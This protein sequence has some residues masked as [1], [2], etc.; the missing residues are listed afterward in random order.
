MRTFRLESTQRFPYPRRDIFDFFSRAENLERITPP[1]LRFAV[2]TP[3]PIRMREGTC[4]DYRLRL[5]GIPL[6]WRS[7]ITLWDPPNAFIDIQL[8]GP[9]R[10]WAHTHTFRDTAHGTLV[11]DRVEYAVP[12]GELVNR[13]IVRPDLDRVFEYRRRALRVLFPEPARD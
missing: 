8:C 9:Y 4:I 10:H 6:A 11:E 12:G 5:R 3:M 13:F 1:W 2:Q 7:E